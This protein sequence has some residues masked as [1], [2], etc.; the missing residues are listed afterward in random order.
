MSGPAILSSRAVIGMLLASI[1]A[2]KQWWGRVVQVVNSNQLNGEDYGF[3]GGPNPMEETNSDPQPGEPKVFPWFIR[4][5]HFQVSARIPYLEFKH[6]S[7]DKLRQ[8]LASH[9]VVAGNHPGILL[10]T[11]INN[12]ESNTCYDGLAFFSASHPYQLD[13]ADT[14]QSNLISKTVAS[15]TAITEA[16]MEQALLEAIARFAILRD[17]KGNEING[18]V[19]DYVL[20]CPAALWPFAEKALRKMNI[21]GGSSNIFVNGQN[22]AVKADGLSFNARPVLLPRMTGTLVDLYAETGADGGPFIQQ[23]LEDTTEKFLGPDSEHCALH[24]EVVAILRRSYNLAY[25]RYQRAVRVK[26]AQ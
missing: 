5:R 7:P 14:T 18:N 1:S 19:Q 15:T 11:L 22:V 9:G 3:I 23:V 21:S 20:A 17:N 16:E 24:N 8:W 13:G 10:S 26:F 4:N 2:G 6:A 25:G 12:A